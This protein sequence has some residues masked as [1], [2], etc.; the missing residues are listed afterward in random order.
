MSR[1]VDVP[2]TKN[3]AAHRRALQPAFERCATPLGW[4]WGGG[5][6]PNSGVF[7]PKF[8]FIV[9]RT[10]SWCIFAVLWALLTVFHAR[11]VLCEYSRNTDDTTHHQAINANQY[12]NLVNTRSKYAYNT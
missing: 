5:F 4:G 11:L 2:L 6:P 8:I 12:S 10:Y 7:S 1:A 9:L 3:S